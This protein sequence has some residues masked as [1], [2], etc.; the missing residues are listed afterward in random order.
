MYRNVLLTNGNKI[1]TIFCA[2]GLQFQNYSINVKPHTSSIGINKNA[3]EV[4]SST[5]TTTINKTKNVSSATAAATS[6]K[7]LVAEKVSG[8]FSMI[9]GYVFYP[10]I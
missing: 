9:L 8:S 10:K 3:K 5:T 2:G 6:T 7:P 1:K 4:T